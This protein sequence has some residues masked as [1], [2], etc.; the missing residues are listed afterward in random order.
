[1]NLPWR[2][3]EKRRNEKQKQKEKRETKTPRGGG[4]VVEATV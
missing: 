4:L 3:K 2:N 1:V